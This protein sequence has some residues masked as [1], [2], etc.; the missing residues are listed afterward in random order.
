M[1]LALLVA[2]NNLFVKTCSSA[3]N[4]SLKCAIEFCLVNSIIC[5]LANATKIAR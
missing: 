2:D 4:C 3:K 5:A 1:R